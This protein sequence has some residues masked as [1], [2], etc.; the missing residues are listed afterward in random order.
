M[1]LRD[2][3]KAFDKEW[4]N[5]FK[6]KI[7]R[8]RLPDILEKILCN[9]LEYRKAKINIGTKFSKDINILSGVPEGSV[10]SP[11]LYTLFTN[12]LSPSEYGCLHNMYAD[13]VTQIITSPSKSVNVE[14]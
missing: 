6:Y 3:T 12:D 1:V 2:V 7:L 5:G 8:L 9:F 10:L 11:T 4:R 14:D 13:D